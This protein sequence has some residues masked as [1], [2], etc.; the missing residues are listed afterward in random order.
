M[1]APAP[2][3]SGFTFPAWVSQASAIALSVLGVLE[4]LRFAID[5][6]L[7]PPWASIAFAVAIGLVA[8]FGEGAGDHDGDGTP[9][10][11]DREWWATAGKAWLAKLAGLVAVVRGRAAP[12]SAPGTIATDHTP[13]DPSGD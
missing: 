1:T 9:N 6:S 2:K 3:K 12:P 10:L 11:F 5:W 8:A 13:T 4:M 7:V